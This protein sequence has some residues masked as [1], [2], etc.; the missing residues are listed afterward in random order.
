VGELAGEVVIWVDLFS[1]RG[2]GA[3]FARCE[4]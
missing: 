2:E 4:E 1:P 3:E